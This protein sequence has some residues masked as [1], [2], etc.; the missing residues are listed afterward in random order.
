MKTQTKRPWSRGDKMLVIVPTVLVVLALGGFLWNRAAN[1]L[2]ASLPPPHFMP[3]VNARDYY[4][5][6]TNALVDNAKIEYAVSPWPPHGLH[7][8]GSSPDDHFYSL[9]AKEKLVTENAPVLS[10]L[11]QGFQYPYQEVATRSFSTTY[12]HYQK[13]RQLARLLSL[14]GQVKAAHE[15]WSGAVSAEL[16][17]VQMGETMP[18][19]AGVLGMLVG[20]ACQG[21]GRKHVWEAVPNLSGLE[22]QAAARRLENIRTAHVSFADTMLKEKWGMQASLRELMA[23]PNWSYT[24]IPAINGTNPTSSQAWAHSAYL[25]VLGKKRILTTN[26]QWMDQ[27]I[28]QAHQ[29]YAAHL[30]PPPWPGDQV[31]MTLLPA[32]SKVRLNEVSSDTQN[33]LLVTALALQAYHQDQKA[34]PVTLPALVP[35]YLK[36]VPTDP[37]TLS[38]PLRYKRT[39]ATYV[40]YSAGPDGRDDGGRAIFDTTKPSPSPGS[41]NDERRGVSENS[42]GDVVAGVNVTWGNP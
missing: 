14:D 6:A 31:N 20:V 23:K 17:A 28:A 38:G 42:T 16:D 10:L 19:G 12:P 25:Q 1:T 39:G 37:F 15:D 40:L 24:L 2:P 33:A 35:G 9:A 30:P 3:A 18:H 26:A 32:Y 41:T 29:P 36:A 8:V 7:G 27:A 13:F 4:I 5:T 34:Y 21:I 11:H 22:G